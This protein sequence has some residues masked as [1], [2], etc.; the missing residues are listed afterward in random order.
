MPFV[1]STGLPLGSVAPPFALGGV[2]GQV[3]SL[4]SFAPAELVVVVFTCN[5]CPV[6]V[7]VEDRLIALQRDYSAR[8]VR[9][10]AINPNDASTHPDDSFPQMVARAKDKGFNFPYLRDETQEVAIAYRA[11]CTP[12]IFVVD[13]HH[14]IVYMGRIDDCWQDEARV[15]RRDLR[16]ALDALLAGEPLPFESVPAT[17][18]SIKWKP[19]RSG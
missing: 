5:H 11:M 8:G 14:K 19:G 9:L 12:D 16:L 4:E 13:R 18:C 17:G 2:D 7:A 3:W 1:Q 10:C 15:E 6:A